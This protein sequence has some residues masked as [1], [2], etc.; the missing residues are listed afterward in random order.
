MLEEKLYKT[1]H[2][3]HVK[4]WIRV[5]R[6]FFPHGLGIGDASRARP[7]LTTGLQFSNTRSRLAELIF[8]AANEWETVIMSTIVQ[9]KLRE[10]LLSRVT[11]DEPQSTKNLVQ[12]IKVLEELNKKQMR[13]AGNQAL[14][15][16]FGS[17]IR[18]LCW[19]VTPGRSRVCGRGIIE[20]GRGKLQEILTALDERDLQNYFYRIQ[21]A[22]A[23]LRSTHQ[24]CSR[25]NRYAARVSGGYGPSV[26]R[27]PGPVARVASRSFKGRRSREGVSVEVYEAV[28]G[29]E[30]LIGTFTLRQLALV[31]LA[32]RLDIVAIAPFGDLGDV[33]I[34]PAPLILNHDCNST[35]AFAIG[36][37]ANV[38]L[39]RDDIDVVL[40]HKPEFSRFLWSVFTRENPP[41]TYTS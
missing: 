32:T 11:L 12:G 6:A 2:A 35:V 30:K 9:G 8:L 33:A 10:I 15:L 19:W 1:H 29:L 18:E 16:C 34:S 28:A 7:G 36:N 40:F 24:K 13:T 31:W 37:P 5:E 39:L 21:H 14:Q 22:L 27:D 38:D 23:A 17:S 26:A 41:T 20:H 4:A 25:V 3:L